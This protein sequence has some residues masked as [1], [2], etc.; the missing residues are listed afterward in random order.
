MKFLRHLAGY[1]PVNIASGLAAFGTVY[2]FTRLL[3]ADEYGRYALMFTVMSLVHMLS[4]TA[5]E[6]AAFRFT[7]EA[8]TKKTLP[9]HFRTTLSLTLRSLGVAA[10]L[11]GLLA[12][13]LRQWPEY[14]AILPWIAL[15]IPINSMVQTALEAH[16]ASERVG[17]YA[18]ISTTQT[19]LGFLAGAWIAWQTGFGA[20]SPFIGLVIGGVFWSMTETRWLFNQAKGGATNAAR[21]RTYLWYG[22]PIAA[23]LVLD[24]ILAAADRVLIAVFLGEAAVGEYAAGYGV[25]DKSVLMI[26]AWA[27]MAAVPLVMA[28]YD[29]EG[30]AAAAEESKGLI[31]TL[32]LLGIP[33][34]TG[35]A[36]VAEPLSE[37]LIGEAVRDGARQIIPWIAFA[38][39]LNGLNIHYYASVFHHTHRTGELALLMV[40]PAAAN[41]ALNLVLI[42]EFGLTGAVAATIVSYLLAL[43]VLAIRGRRLIALPLP[44]TDLLK[45]SAAAACM[46]PVIWLIPDL[47]AWPELV[48]KIAAGGAIYV[49]LAFALDAGGAR[50]FVRDKLASKGHASA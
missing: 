42:P 36:L 49:I 2:V 17:R 27:A 43:I 14:L 15:L 41:I 13:F 30:P 35:L 11:L 9:D 37:A 33:A 7:S 21:R 26:C 50:G 23:A 22:A 18:L 16:R 46:A 10:V 28:A 48:L 29:R 32:L 31:R 4:M 1:L 20:S 45:V 38:G 34:A 39:L 3:D 5:A 12:L 24:T 40:I 25:A 44:L 8:E 6:A 47:S 19:L